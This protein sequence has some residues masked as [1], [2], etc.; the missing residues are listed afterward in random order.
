MPVQEK[1]TLN[2]TLPGVI[3]VNSASDAL[4]ITQTGA[5]N[6]L[7]VE[8]SANPDST[9]FVINAS[10][11]VALGKTTASALLDIKL[12]GSSINVTNDGDIITSRTSFSGANIFRNQRAAGT[13][14][15]PSIVSSG[16]ELIRIEGRGYDGSSYITAGKIEFWV[17]GTPGTNDMP[18]R[19]VFYTTA[20]GASSSTERIR[21]TNDGRVGIGNAINQTDSI[22]TINH[23]L[24]NGTTTYGFRNFSTVPST[25][26][27]NFVNNQSLSTTQAA[28]FSLV[29]YQHFLAGQN[30]IGAGSAITNQYGYTAEASLN[31]AT[32][33]Y[34]FFGNIASGTGRWN[35]YASGT[36]RNY[37]A[38]GV[39]VLA[40]TTTQA[41]GFLNCSAAAGVPTGVPT[42]P[43]GNVPIYYDTTNN[44]LYVY[45]GAWRSTAALT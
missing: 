25:T 44:K 14:A 38:G 18:G 41:V 17:D 26:T 15:S 39:E 43:T 19:L 13:E 5:G 33:N 34:G 37:F 40:G 16:L 36:A 27:S 31:G 35:F 28:A 11:Q 23:L 9:P 21:I 2:T 7:V 29:N 24:V 10:G 6:A 22:F 3:S 32:N 30:S 42:N 12:G 45:N 8:D 1:N 4:R 20:D